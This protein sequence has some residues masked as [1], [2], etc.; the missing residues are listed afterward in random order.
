[1]VIICDVLS[2]VGRISVWETCPE[3]CFYSLSR[4]E[5]E[6]VYQRFPILNEL[7]IVDYSY[8]LILSV[9]LKGRR[10]IFPE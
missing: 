6:Y 9:E 10:D 8:S 4:M 7:S 1:M 2:V 3:G 5:Y